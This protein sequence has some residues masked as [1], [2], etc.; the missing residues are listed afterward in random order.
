MHPLSVKLMAVKRAF[1]RGGVI[2]QIERESGFG[3]GIKQ[4]RRQNLHTGEN[5]GGA[6][7]FRVGRSAGQLPVI[8]PIIIARAVIAGGLAFELG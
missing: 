7:A 6:C 2:G 3:Q 4:A 1:F 8:A 5:I